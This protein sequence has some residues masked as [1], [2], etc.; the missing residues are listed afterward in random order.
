MLLY[1]HHFLYV[2]VSQDVDKWNHQ[3]ANNWNVFSRETAPRVH[4][5]PAWFALS[6]TGVGREAIEG[7]DGY[8]ILA[9]PPASSSDSESTQ[10]DQDVKAKDA[11][12]FISWEF[13]GASVL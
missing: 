3:D 10:K 2:P 5:N 12:R 1:A 9:L 13:I 4:K 7:K 11:R 8:T 6:A